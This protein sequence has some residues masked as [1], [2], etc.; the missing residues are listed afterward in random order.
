MNAP[1]STDQE[2]NAA[3]QGEDELGMVVRAHIYIEAA[4]NDLLEVLLV[5]PRHVEKMNL[6]FSQ[7]VRLAVALGLLPQYESPLLA[8]GTLRNAFAHRPGT[9]LTKGK[10][11][12]LYSSLSP[13]DK[14]IVQT[15]HQRTR[16]QAPESKVPRWAELS[17]RDRFILIA[18]GLRALLHVAHK[19]AV[20]RKHGA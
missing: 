2:F 7:K 6:D 19:Q 15:S 12:S 18:V 14:T 3:L 17:P 5:S 9:A 20:G 11:D 4:L 1:D 8:L 13:E 16:K 10:V